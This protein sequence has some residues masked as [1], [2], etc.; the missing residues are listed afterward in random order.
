MGVFCQLFLAQYSEIQV[1]GPFDRLIFSSP[2]KRHDFQANAGIHLRKSWM[3]RLCSVAA[4]SILHEQANRA[5][6]VQG[7]DA[8][9]F[10]LSF[11]CF[12]CFFCE[13][14]SSGHIWFLHRHNL[15]RIISGRKR[16]SVHDIQSQFSL[17]SEG[18]LFIT[19]DKI[20]RIKLK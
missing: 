19:N 17:S 8:L 20:Q 11:L 15:F 10:Y 5:W 4:T 9:C 6:T 14:S 7:T 12:F 13:R 16:S 1:K 2:R 18:K 3:S